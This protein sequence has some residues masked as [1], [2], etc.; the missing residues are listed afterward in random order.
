MGV[1]DQG[2]SGDARFA[3]VGFGDAPVDDV[4]TPPTS[5]GTFSVF[6]QYGNM[7][8]DDMPVFRIQTEFLQN[9]SADLP[10]PVQV[11]VGRIDFPGF[12]NALVHKCSFKE[13]HFALAVQGGIGA[14][15]QVPQEVPGFDLFGRVKGRKVGTVH[16]FADPVQQFP[17][18]IR[19]RPRIFSDMGQPHFPEGTVLVQGNA[20]V[21]Q[22]IA[23][24]GFVHGALGVQEFDVAV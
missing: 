19:I 24:A 6:Q 9:L 4:E 7:A 10:A 12:R 13:G 1:V 16:D 17:A 23:V 20:A 3:A 2:V 5:D 8:V 22:Q 15:P 14:A 11:V 21:V 18:M